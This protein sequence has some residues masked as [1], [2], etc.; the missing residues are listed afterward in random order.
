MIITKFYVPIR[1][2][3]ETGNGKIHPQDRWETLEN[4]IYEMFDGLTCSTVPFRG[5]WRDEKG[6][7]MPDVSRPYSVY[8]PE[9]RL[10]EMKRFIPLVA[11]M[12][13]QR[14]IAFECQGEA[15]LIPQKT[16]KEK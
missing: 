11:V 7:I 8:V 13:R 12:F 4:M 15:E 16:Y 10:V 6:E 9:E 3:P 14:C 1:E 2:D 5:G